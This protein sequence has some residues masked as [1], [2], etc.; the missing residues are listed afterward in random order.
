MI[1]PELAGGYVMKIYNCLKK[2]TSEPHCSTSGSQYPS[3]EPIETHDEN[4]NDDTIPIMD[5]QLFTVADSFSNASITAASSTSPSLVESDFSD[6]APNLISS[7]PISKEFPI[8]QYTFAFYG[9]E[10]FR[11]GIP[12]EL[13]KREITSAIINFMQKYER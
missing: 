11:T 6:C 13:G 2:P 9:N 5:E 12:T 8:D 10:V 7:N 4:S 3:Y 1:L